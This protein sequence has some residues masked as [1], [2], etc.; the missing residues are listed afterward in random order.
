MASLAAAT[1][2]KKFDVYLFSQGKKPLSLDVL[3]PPVIKRGNGKSKFY[4]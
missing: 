2:E 3:Y 4:K 1:R